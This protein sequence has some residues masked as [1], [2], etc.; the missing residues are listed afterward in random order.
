[1]VGSVNLVRSKVRQKTMGLLAPFSGR[2]L[3]A[4]G[5]VRA[6]WMVVQGAKAPQQNPAYQLARSPSR[7]VATSIGRERSFGVVSRERATQV[8]SIHE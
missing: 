6:R 4:C 3:D 5:N 8:D 2:P 1:M 7:P